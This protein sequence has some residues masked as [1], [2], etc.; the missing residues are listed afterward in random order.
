M[1]ACPRIIGFLPLLAETIL[2]G[3]WAAFT[4]E[5]ARGRALLRLYAGMRKEEEDRM[6]RHL[7]PGL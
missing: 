4:Q 6:N 7:A 5:S 1:I 2:R 3:R